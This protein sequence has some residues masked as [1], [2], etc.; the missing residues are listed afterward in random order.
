MHIMQ[1]LAHL[2]G[3]GHKLH[4][5]DDMAE[6]EAALSEDVAVVMLTQVSYQTGRLLDMR[7]MT[8]AAH[9]K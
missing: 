9:A 6:Y 5:L 2:M 3:R 4:M 7:S 8:Q 1:G